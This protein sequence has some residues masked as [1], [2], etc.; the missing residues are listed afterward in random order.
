M[1]R[2][3]VT[4]AEE[5]A[6]D[7][8]LLHVLAG[9][10]DM[11]GGP[12]HVAERREVAGRMLELA[13]G[14]GDANG[15]L[16]ARRFLLVALLEVGDFAAADVQ[17]TAFDRLARSTNEPAHLWYPPLW[18]GMRA[19]LAGRESDAEA[20][21][22]QVEALGARAQS[23]NAQML[24]TTLRFAARSGRPEEQV[25]LVRAV[26][27]YAPN[28]PPDLPQF[29]VAQASMYAE[30]R[31]VEATARCYRPLADVGFRSLPEDAEFLS[32][33]LGAVEAAILLDDEVGA[34]ALFDRMSPFAD[35]W[36]VDGIGGACW[37]LTAEWLARLADLLGRGADADR[38]RARAEAAY[39]ATGASGPLRRITGAVD[40]PSAGHARLRREGSG[41]VV[42]WAGAQTTLPDL[43]GLHDLATLVSRPGTPVPAVRLLASGAGVD[44]GPPGGGDEVLDDQARAAY[45]DRLRTLE[46]EIAEASDDADLA[47]AERLRDERA[48]LL[49]ELSAALGLGGRSRRLGDDTDRARKAVTMR[50]RD[51]IARLDDPL[52]ALARHLRAAVRTGRECCYDPEEPVSWRVRTGRPG[53]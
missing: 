23:L 21:A 2:A 25:D 22:D 1:A 16:L 45:R 39:R 5:A 35:V 40:S 52:P 49:R 19:L 37:G 38:L 24:T 47:R 20:Y 8:A 36:I 9:Y 29:L 3:A 4:E 48:F 42:G 32:S 17:I 51:V 28:I 6:D 33:M 50:L 14:L 27:A 53:G 12:R 44:L 13:Q 18:R 41:W 30:V 46:D 43:K 15:E 10:A 31:D 11:I 7:G 34:R 26:E